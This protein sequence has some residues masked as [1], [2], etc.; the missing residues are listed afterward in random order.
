[1]EQ[2]NGNLFEVKLDETGRRYIRKLYRLLTLILIG[3]TIISIAAGV[4]Q[5]HRIIRYADKSIVG[6]LPNLILGVEP[7]VSL[8]LIFIN[9]I[10]L[11]YYYK[12]AKTISSGVDD[13][14][15]I[16]FNE[17]FKFLY[18]N[19]LVNMVSLVLNI[20]AYIIVLIFEFKY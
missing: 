4:I 11:V 12:F 14:N 3:F 6:L 10:A 9:A 2:E 7:M 18:R 19:V 16:R 13:D 17:S 1:M 5:I 15:P 8:F 20:V